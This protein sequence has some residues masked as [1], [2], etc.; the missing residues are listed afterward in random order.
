MQVI[1]LFMLFQTS[2][3]APEV[4]IA[5]KM[6]TAETHQDHTD[7][8]VTPVMNSTWGRQGGSVQV[9]Q[10]SSVLVDIYGLLKSNCI[11]DAVCVP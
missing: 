8:S 6:A 2:M 1:V 3:N 10:H 11:S 4:S 9:I 5:V 7:V